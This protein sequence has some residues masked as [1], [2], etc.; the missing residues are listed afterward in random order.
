MLGRMDTRA[1]RFVM[2]GFASLSHSIAAKGRLWRQPRSN[3]SAWT[4]FWGVLSKA[5]PIP[6]RRWSRTRN[7]KTALPLASKD[8]ERLAL[9]RTTPL[10]ERFGNYS[11]SMKSGS[12]DSWCGSDGNWNTPQSLFS[13]ALKVTLA[14]RAKKA[15]YDAFLNNWRVPCQELGA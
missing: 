11:I 3:K 14:S 10:T 15:T 2:L 5:S 8:V 7:N 1:C 9:K 6:S 12:F 4:V 13:T